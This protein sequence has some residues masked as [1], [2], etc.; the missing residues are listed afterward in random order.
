MIPEETCVRCV[1]PSLIHLEECAG[2]I[3]IIIQVIVFSFI[4]NIIIILL[5]NKSEKEKR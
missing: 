4:F 1:L 5:R 2:W 3:E